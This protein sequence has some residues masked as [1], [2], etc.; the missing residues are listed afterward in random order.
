MV[1]RLG[2]GLLLLASQLLRAVLAGKDRTKMM[3]TR[4]AAASTPAVAVLTATPVGHCLIQ[5]L[6]Y[7]NRWWRRQVHLGPHAGGRDGHLNTG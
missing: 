3:Y 1:V 6:L 4:S 5:A 7:R 2:S